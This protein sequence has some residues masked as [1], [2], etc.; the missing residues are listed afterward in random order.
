MLVV[1]LAALAA[2]AAWLNYKR[3]APSPKLD[4]PYEQF[5]GDN[6]AARY[7]TE[8]LDILTRGYNKVG[9]PGHT[10]AIRSSICASCQLVP[11]GTLN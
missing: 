5:D 2:C 3:P 11:T 1:F 10:R 6:S 4:L 7:I 8:S 9:Y